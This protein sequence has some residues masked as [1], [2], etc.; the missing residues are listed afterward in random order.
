MNRVLHQIKEIRNSSNHADKA[1]VQHAI[2]QL[3]VDN[4]AEEELTNL[5][6]LSTSSVGR[7][8][9]VGF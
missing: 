9:M 7:N 1:C 3:D 6:M 2:W 4:N 8:S 5:V